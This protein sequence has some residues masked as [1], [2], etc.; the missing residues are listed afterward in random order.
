MLEGK[1]GF[2]AASSLPTVKTVP[3]IN[4]GDIL[5]SNIRPYFKKIWL[6][7]SVGGRSNDVLGFKPSDSG[8]AEY[9]Y[10][11]LYQ[12]IFFDFMMTTSKGA[13]MPRG[14]KDAIKGWNCVQ[15]TLEV[16]AAYSGI[17]KAFYSNIE[18]TKKESTALEMLR[19]T[20]LP[21]LLS[22]VPGIDTSETEF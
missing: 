13:K 17:V 6:A 2:T 1:R 10:N 14:D 18:S 5:I 16:R 20:L 3:A 7:S 4:V 22:G 19:N 12:D 15:P 9:L 11:L 8:A 21:K